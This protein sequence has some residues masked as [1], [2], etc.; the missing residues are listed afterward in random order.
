MKALGLHLLL[1]AYHEGSLF[2]WDLLDIG[3]PAVESQ[4][5]NFRN[6]NGEDIEC[7]NRKLSQATICTSSRKSN[8]WFSSIICHD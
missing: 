5:S 3:H 6:F 4:R 1:L 7:F 2:F 8:V